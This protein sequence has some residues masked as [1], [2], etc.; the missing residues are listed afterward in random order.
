MRPERLLPGDSIGLDDCGRHAYIR[1]I[2]RDPAAGLAGELHCGKFSFADMVNT[3]II[4]S[5]VGAGNFFRGRVA[6]MTR[7]IS[8]CA[9]TFACMSHLKSP[10]GV[11]YLR[12]SLRLNGTLLIVSPRFVSGT[13]RV[14][15]VHFV[16]VYNL[17]IPAGAILW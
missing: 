9:T 14:L 2:R 13:N 1:F 11:G 5:T 3:D 4:L 12:I 10:F 7:V 15:S 6:E 16:Y 17:L 8:N